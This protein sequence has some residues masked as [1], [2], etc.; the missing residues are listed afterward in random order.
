[1]TNTGKANP[2]DLVKAFRKA[3]KELGCLQ[4]D[5]RFREELFAIGR[6]KQVREPAKRSKSSR[7]IIP[8]R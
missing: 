2:E 1:M 8:R 6:Y 5:Q 4:S 3:A 7:K